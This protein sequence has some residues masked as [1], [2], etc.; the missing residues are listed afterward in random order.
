MCEFSYVCNSC[1]GVDIAA[2]LMFQTSLRCWRLVSFVDEE[3][4][5]A[6]TKFQYKHSQTK[7]ISASIMIISCMAVKHFGNVLRSNTIF[8]D[9]CCFLRMIKKLDPYTEVLN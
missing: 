7:T 8:Y 4:P 1:C 2:L 6:A 9:F 3:F 5:V